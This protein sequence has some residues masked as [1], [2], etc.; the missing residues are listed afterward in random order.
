MDPTKSGEPILSDRVLVNGSETT[1]T[2]TARG[3]LR[4]SDLSLDVEKEVIGFSVEGSK[5]KIRIVVECTA[6]ICCFAK[7]A[8]TRKNFTLEFSS[9]SSLHSWAQ[10]LHEIIDA[11][12][13]LL[14]IQCIVNIE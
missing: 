7:P 13:K 6:G 3:Q 14:A 2:L 9:D 11:L 12:G 1:A 4:W 5:I 10:K 8:M